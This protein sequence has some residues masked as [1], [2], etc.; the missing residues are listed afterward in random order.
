MVKNIVEGLFNGMIGIV[1][2]LEK[3][4]YIE[5]NFNGNLVI[6]FE[7]IFEVLVYESR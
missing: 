2:Y 6:V 5:D 3:G 4:S 1:Y 7:I